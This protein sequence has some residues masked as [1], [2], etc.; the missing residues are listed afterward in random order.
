MD[1]LKHSLVPKHSKLS[2]NEKAVLLEKYA[3]ELKQLPR[4]YGSDPA[5]SSLSVKEGDIIKIERASKTAGIFAYYRVVTG[6]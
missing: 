2:D 4:I 3:A 1:A 5:L 6:N